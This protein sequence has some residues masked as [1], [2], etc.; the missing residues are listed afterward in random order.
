MEADTSFFNDMS[1]LG[2]L[3]KNDDGVSG[4]FSNIV[5][6]G[7]MTETS[8]GSSSS[9]NSDGG[10][11]G[12]FSNIVE[13]GNMT[14]TISGSSSSNSN[15]NESG[16]SGSNNNCIGHNSNENS[17]NPA[18]SDGNTEPAGQGD[19]GRKSLSEGE[20]DDDTSQLL[21]D[22]SEEVEC[23]MCFDFLD[24]PRML[25]ACTHTFCC[26]CLVDMCNFQGPSAG[27][28]IECPLCRTASPLPPAGVTALPPNLYLANIVDKLRR[29][30]RFSARMSARRPSAGSGRGSAG[31]PTLPHSQQQL[32]LQQQQPQQH[33]HQQFQQ[34]V[35]PAH[36]HM[37]R[38]PPHAYGPPQHYPPSL[39]A[40]QSLPGAAP[41]HAG[42]YPHPYQTSPQHAPPSHHAPPTQYPYAPAPHPH[43]QLSH[44]YGQASQMQIV[45]PAAMGGAPPPAAVA[46]GPDL[47]TPFAEV[48]LL[49]LLLFLVGPAFGDNSNVFIKPRFPLTKLSHALRI[50][51]VS[52]EDV[53]LMLMDNTA[54]AWGDSDT[55]LLS[56][57]GLYYHN[58]VERK[59]FDRQFSSAF[60]PWPLLFSHAITS[61]GRGTVY[62][63]SKFA[64]NLGLRSFRKD[65]LVQLLCGMRARLMEPPPAPY[66]GRVPNYKYSPEMFCSEEARVLFVLNS[67]ALTPREKLSLYTLP[68][69]PKAKLINACAACHLA[70]GDKVLGLLDTTTFGSA[71]NGA[72][73][74]VYGIYYCNGGFL[75]SSSHGF[76][77]YAD[78]SPS[79]VC[80][81]GMVRLAHDHVIQ[82]GSSTLGK[83]RLDDLVRKLSAPFVNQAR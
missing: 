24:D 51:R 39:H 49:Q 58:K 81:F 65:G 33:P 29:H 76:V 66:S 54:A 19:D 80:D 50:C 18:C 79:D 64:V 45:A 31:T 53:V 28:R 11:S 37:Q 5:E 47:K 61:D 25:T 74:S 21:L 78:V 17:N 59:D 14:E 40:P 6:C 36:P 67:L 52:H 55:V 82:I 4:G 8:S 32:Q 57:S 9:S 44:S 27:T 73:F 35:M 12:G 2:A 46:V 1:P 43:P 56:L 63:A 60:I 10:V 83:S 23:P 48:T 7:H 62:L 71:R 22:L 30:P 38:Y 77:R 70:E 3:E 20:P 34:P 16:S 26:S 72:L 13:C 75:R 41:V 69:L 15:N 42:Y 68:N